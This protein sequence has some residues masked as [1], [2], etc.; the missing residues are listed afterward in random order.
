VTRATEQPLPATHG[1][2][3]DLDALLVALVLV[4]HS[5]P[6]NRFYALY[7]RPEAFSVRRRAALLRS[8]IA[9]LTGEASDVTIS[10]ERDVMTLRYALPE[11]GARRSTRLNAQELAIVKLA[12]ERLEEP[13]DAQRLAC[14]S[15]VDQLPSVTPL[16]ERLY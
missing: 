15:Q 2:R 6:R 8:L 1:T 4:P 14:L 12:V 10:R 7:S 13:G 5:Y 3:V 11:M 16:L 9:D